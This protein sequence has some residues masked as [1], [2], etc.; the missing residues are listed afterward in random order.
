MGL[1]ALAVAGGKASSHVGKVNG[2]PW[3]GEFIDEDARTRACDLGVVTII[4]SRLVVVA[5]H[6][7]HFVAIWAVPEG[8]PSS[9]G[10]VFT[11]R[12]VG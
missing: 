5:C 9:G 1:N 4:G 2:A 11:Q 6:N 3:P 10:R 12:V 8:S 7:D